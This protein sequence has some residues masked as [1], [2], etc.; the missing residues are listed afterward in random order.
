[1]NLNRLNQDFLHNRLLSRSESGL[2]RSLKVHSHLVDFCSNDYLGFTRSVVLKQKI[3]DQLKYFTGS[4]AGSTGSRLLSGNSVFTVEVEDMIA[5]FHNAEAG[6]IFNSGYDANLSLFS[7]LPQRGDLIIYDELI[8]ASVH[9]GMRLSKAEKISFAH[10][11]VADLEE[12]LR[13]SRNQS[14]VNQIFVGVESL[15]SMDGDVALLG[16]MTDLC[17]QYG[18][19]FIVDEAH[20]TGVMGKEG[21][22][23]VQELGLEDRVFA[24][25]HTFGKALGCHGAIVLGSK[26]LREYLVN[27]ARP[28]IYSTALPAHS[29]AAVKCA[30]TMLST[31]EEERAKLIELIYLFQSIP[32][33]A[34]ECMKLKSDSPIQGIIVPGNERC[35]SAALLLQQNGFDVRPILSPTVPK[36]K[37]RL[38]ICIH[39]FNTAEEIKGMMDSLNLFQKM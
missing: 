2:L 11:D 13:E 6:L 25:M 32:L 29:L 28:L 26:T 18:A 3:D 19:C 21:R 36:G 39:A 24:R 37:E 10:N 7:A 4:V 22:G 23:L 14:G 38:R 34:A 16:E 31:A 15:Y 12:K 8:H 1:M 9:D 20:A 33:K 27:F 35:R 5:R 17:D 30:Y